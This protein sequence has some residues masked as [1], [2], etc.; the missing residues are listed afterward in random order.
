MNK[1]YI[2]RVSRWLHIYLSMVSFLIV[3][4][5]SVTGLTLNHA[6]YFQAN[7]TT[8]IEK[9]KVQ[10]DWVS[11]PDTQKIKKLELVEF[12]RNK[13]ALK[14]AIAD[15]RIDDAEI[16]F[17]LKAPGYEASIFVE[18]ETGSYEITQTSQ[19]LIGFLNDLH[20][21]RDTGR[22]WLWV[23]DIAAVLMVLISLTG[24]VLLFY[25]K[26]KRLAGIFLLI[27]GGIISYAVYQFWGQ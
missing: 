16:S 14:G 19:G 9:G 22:T 27:I 7:S 17:S 3:L 6:D 5:F 8:I 24:L 2:A 20:K 10:P 23:I 21:G 13:Y 4:F 1:K 25:L 12:L 15:F 11:V 18:R 26:K